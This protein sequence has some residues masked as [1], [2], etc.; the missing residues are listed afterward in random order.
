[1]LGSLGICSN[2][3]DQSAGTADVHVDV[4]STCRAVPL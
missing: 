2:S 1:M 4:R 3:P